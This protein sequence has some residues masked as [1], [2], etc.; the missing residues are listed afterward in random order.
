M[1]LQRPRSSRLRMWLFLGS[2][3]MRCAWRGFGNNFAALA[4]QVVDQAVGVLDVA[5][6]EVRLVLDDDTAVPQEAEPGGFDTVDRDFQDRSQGRAPLDEQ[7]DARAVKADH[8]GVFAGDFE[9]EMV[10]IEGSRLLR[11]WGLDEDV[12]AKGVCHGCSSAC[13]VEV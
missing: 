5:S 3:M 12:G 2:W 6:R 8:L 10:D 11:V 9:A 7:V 1:R 13:L 4:G